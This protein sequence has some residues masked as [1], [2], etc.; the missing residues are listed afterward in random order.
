M[1]INTNNLVVMTE[2]SQ[3]FSKGVRLVDENGME[4]IEQARIAR[5]AKIDETADRLIEENLE[6]F[7]ELAK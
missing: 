6:A 5:A 7:L 3:N 1:R 2:A 4:E